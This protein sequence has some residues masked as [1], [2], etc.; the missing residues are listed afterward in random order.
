MA[1]W[2]EVKVCE[3]RLNLRPV[4]CMPWHTSAAA[5]AASGTI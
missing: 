2:S 4:C 5:A 1:V 3:C